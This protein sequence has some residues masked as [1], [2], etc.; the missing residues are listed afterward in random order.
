MDRLGE[1]ER[2]LRDVAVKRRRLESQLSDLQDRE[3]RLRNAVSVLI[4]YGF[5]VESE[6][7]DESSDDLEH[8]AMTMSAAAL[9]ILSL[10]GPMSVSELA[11]KMLEANFPYDRG[12]GA[13]EMSL[14]GALSRGVKTGD[15][16]RVERGVYAVKKPD[17]PTTATTETED[18]FAEFKP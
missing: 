12:P 11:D 6:S 10:S 2:D 14:R 9:V 8:G 13:L 15:L 18:V 1:I 16:E 5:D 17:E 4:E 7:G 3:N